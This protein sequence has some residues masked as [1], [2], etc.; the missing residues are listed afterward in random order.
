MYGNGF[1]FGIFFLPTAVYGSVLLHYAS[2][3]LDFFSKSVSWVQYW[4]GDGKS[5]HWFSLPTWK[6]IGI[7]LLIVI[8][9][10]FAAVMIENILVGSWRFDFTQMEEDPLMVDS[11]M[12]IILGAVGG[13]FYGFFAMLNRKETFDF[14]NNKV[15]SGKYSGFFTW[16]MFLA[17]VIILLMFLFLVARAVISSGIFAPAWLA[18]MLPVA[19]TTFFLAAFM[20]PFVIA[21]LGIYFLLGGLAEAGSGKVSPTN[22]KSVSMGAPQQEDFWAK[23]ARM[24]ASGFE[25]SM[26]QAQWVN[27]NPS[28]DD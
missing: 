9:A 15:A 27:K 20:V 3:H 28:N 5:I 10:W 2:G 14:I 6:F 18:C 19:G 13:G 17:L 7:C 25:Y 22:F 4:G 16:L 23:N 24:Q 26:T 11:T 21:V 1:F 8:G 12:W